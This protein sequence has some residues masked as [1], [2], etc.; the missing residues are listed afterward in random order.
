MCSEL[1]I[2]LSTGVV[3]SLG[4][5]ITNHKRNVKT[6]LHLFKIQLHIRPFLS[7]PKD[8]LLSVPSEIHIACLKTYFGHSSFK[9]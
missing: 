3:Q 1:D 4:L 9:P 8:P 2:S 6:K 7:P 5:S